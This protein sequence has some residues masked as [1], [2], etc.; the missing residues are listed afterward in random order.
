MGRHEISD[1]VRA[2]VSGRYEKYKIHC[3]SKDVTMIIEHNCSNVICQ[4]K[5]SFCYSASLL[6]TVS[7]YCHTV[8][9]IQFKADF[10]Q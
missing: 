1:Y 3:S 6:G 2:L 4:S 10:I 9:D 5:H 7:Q 8:A